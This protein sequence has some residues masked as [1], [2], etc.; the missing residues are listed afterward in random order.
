MN[1]TLF[2]GFSVGFAV[3]LLISGSARSESPD[4][5]GITASKLQKWESSDR[6]TM[7][8]SFI[9]MKSGMVGL[10]KSSQ[11]FQVPLSSLSRKSREL[12]EWLERERTLGMEALPE[13]V[14]KILVLN[15][16]PIHEGRRLHEIFGWSDPRD[17]A[18]GYRKDMEAAAGGRLKFEIVEWRNLDQIYAQTGGARYIVEDYVRRR[19]DNS[20]PEG[21]TADYPRIFAEQKVVPLIDQG[22]VDEVWIFSDHFFGLYEGSMAGPNAFNIN[23]GVYS[24]VP[25]SRPFAFHGF[26]YERGVA[27]MTHNTSHRT[28]RVMNRIYGDW[29][30]ENPQNNWEKFSANNTQSK[31]VAG[32]GTC[33][34]PPNAMSDYDYGNLRLVDSWADDFLNYPNLTGA[35]QKVSVATWSVKGGDHHRNYMKWYFGHLPRASGLNP[36]GRLNNWWPYLYDFSNYSEK[37]V[38]RPAFAKVAQIS[39]TR[40]QVVIHVGFSSSKGILPQ[41]FD[42]GD[43]AIFRN[44]SATAERAV[45][46]GIADERPGTYRV[47]SYVFPSVTS[48]VLESST[49]V[50]NAGEITEIDGDSLPVTEWAFIPVS[51]SLV[52]VN[53]PANRKSQQQIAEWV[54]GKGGKIAVVG[55]PR[56]IEKSNE[57]PGENELQIEQLMIPETDLEREKLTFDDLVPLRALKQLRNL[58]LRGT[59]IRDRGAEWIAQVFP[60]LV[61]LNLHNCSVT[62]A[63]LPAIARLTKLES[64]DLGYNHFAITD[65]GAKHLAKLGKLQRLNLHD[66]AITDRTLVEVCARLDNLK[67]LHLL[68]TKVSAQGVASF[69]AS[70]P[71]CIVEGFTP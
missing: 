24:E 71:E 44:G 7:M 31:G 39:E 47:A 5:A 41:S 45:S 29:N 1:L 9:E 10:K 21:V 11:H 51:G 33:H 3:V 63:C 4:G 70:R 15:Y 68:G 50:L 57:L 65:D 66:T 17:L 13:M 54:L 60:E 28:E 25:S 37:G 42:M 32:V 61:E 22:V 67:W 20:L 2:E 46:V 62:N 35:T 56:L 64:L 38:S 34:W 55:D 58:N 36:D 59:H 30:L 19:K 6:R 23:G 26:N 49:L 43:L 16:D 52:A 8:A 48:S 27:E 18:D 12:A 14:V 53:I 69:K 40:D